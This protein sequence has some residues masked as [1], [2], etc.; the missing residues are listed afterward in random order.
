[1]ENIKHQAI[2]IKT[3]KDKVF[4][5]VEVKSACGSCALKGACGIG[6][7]ADKTVEIS[8]D[9]ASSY[10]V[11][12]KI[13]VVLEQSSGF[14]ALFLGYLLPL[15]LTLLVLFG[16]LV[17]GIS[18]IASGIC[19]IIILIPYYFC[20]SLCNKRLQKKFLFKIDNQ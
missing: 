10:P 16:M 9:K 15:L 1:M 11:G 7:C 18:E 5:K 19:A 3:E 17:F 14:F 4:A 13:N 8:T 12:T 2:V 6:D 20:L